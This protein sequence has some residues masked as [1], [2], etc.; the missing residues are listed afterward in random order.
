[1]QDSSLQAGLAT[2]TWERCLVPAATVAVPQ[3]TASST[4]QASKDWPIS[5]TGVFNVL[6][7]TYI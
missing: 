5:N 1:M 3:F 2:K 4:I 6:G 7:E